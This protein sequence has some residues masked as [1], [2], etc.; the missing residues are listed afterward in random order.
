VYL[1]YKS[2]LTLLFAVTPAKA[3][4]RVYISSRAA[5]STKGAIAQR[6]APD[7]KRV[8]APHPAGYVARD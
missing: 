5:R 6:I 3:G 1:K 4:P 7:V 2:N 8:P